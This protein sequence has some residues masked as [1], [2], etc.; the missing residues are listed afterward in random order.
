M[1]DFNKPVHTRDGKPVRVFCTN[2]NNLYSIV[3][4]VSTGEH[5]ELES[6]TKDGL[7]YNDGM[8]RSK[9]L[10]QTPVKRSVWLNIYP[11]RV[12]SYKDKV[13]ADMHAMQDRTACIEVHYTEGEGLE[14]V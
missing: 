1:I 8:Q 10:V 2:L 14:D 5:E 11:D 9:D 13:N 6:W 7:I 12:I 3:G 4:A